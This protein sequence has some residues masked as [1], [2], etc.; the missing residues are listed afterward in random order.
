MKSKNKQT[1]Y[2]NKMAPGLN[3]TLRLLTLTG[4][5]HPRD[6]ERSRNFVSARST[7]SLGR[8]GGDRQAELL[9]GVVMYNGQMNERLGS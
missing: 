9:R 5:I 3:V 8:M 2:M 7:T 4:N 6:L 1:D